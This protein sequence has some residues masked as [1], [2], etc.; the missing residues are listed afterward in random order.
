M[1]IVVLDGYTL[2]PGDL[3][4]D[5]ISKFGDLKVYDRTPY[6]DE[7]IIENIGNADIVF[8]NKTPINKY[9]LSKAA[10]L[11]Y[12]GVL[13]TGYNV[14]DTETAKQQ[15]I[16]VTN[17]PDYSSVAVAQFTIALILEL[18]HHIG[19][20]NAAVQKGDWIKSKD[21]SFWNY[22][23][24]ELAGKTL[25]LI[26]FGKIGRATAKIAKAFGMK[27]LVHNRTVYPEFENDNL[28]FVTLDE[29]LSNS[30]VISLHSPL[31][32]DTNGIINKNTISKMKSSAFLINTARGPLVNENDL[33][34]ALNS[35]K[36]A[37]A[38]LDVI[39]EEPMKADNPLLNA[40]NCIITPHIAW[41]PKEAR[42]RLMQT[43]IDN[44]KCFLEGR[45]VNVV[46]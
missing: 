13:A 32:K 33:V 45:P 37:G 10:S 41:A 34:E 35:E 31:T 42:Q 24:I 18:C 2:N 11:K 1:K 19:A 15:N 12:I 5:G 44:L 14:V 26:G 3:N 22:P 40:K 17:V 23:L 43:T 7:A 4:W 16:V 46:N 9:V 21:F 38:A 20:H 8:T 29:L 6:N 25:G 39:S 36:L 28:K 30:D 27:I